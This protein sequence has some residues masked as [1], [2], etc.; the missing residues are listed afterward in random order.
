MARFKEQL[1]HNFIREFTMWDDE[2]PEIALKLFQL[3]TLRLDYAEFMQWLYV[4]SN[5]KFR[6]H[7]FKKRVVLGVWTHMVFRMK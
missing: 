1:Y 3:M 2:D 6:E 5:Q 7:V 4:D